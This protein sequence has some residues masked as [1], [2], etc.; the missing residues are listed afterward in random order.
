MIRLDLG[1]GRR[2]RQGWTGVDSNPAVGPDVLHSLDV[3]PYPFQDSSVDEIVMDNSL[4]H[5]D[6]QLAVMEELHRISKPGGLITL[7]VPYFRSH[8][9]FND[10]THVRFFSVETFYHYDPAH[11]YNQLYPYLKARYTVESIRFNERINR[12][13]IRTLTKWLANRWPERYE[14]SLSHLIPLDELT[15]RLRVL[16]S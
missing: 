6:E 4:E 15:F 9:A 8:W 14:D 16:K 2:K 13:P 12:G 11:P 10:Q 7:H 1:C 3:F 5:L